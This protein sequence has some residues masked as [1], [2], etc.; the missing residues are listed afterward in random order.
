MEEAIMNT[1]IAN[2]VFMGQV[3]NQER[4]M[5]MVLGL[6]TIVAILSGA[7]TSEGHMFVAAVL[8]IYLGITAIMGLDPFYFVA[9]KLM[10]AQPNKSRSR[11]FAVGENQALR[12]V[13]RQSRSAA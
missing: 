9:E 5:R 12:V 13:S 7:I 6:S 10:Q 11:D 3:S 1:V 8:C 2:Q 4:A